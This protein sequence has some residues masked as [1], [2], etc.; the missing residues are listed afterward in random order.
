MQLERGVLRS[1]N[2]LNGVCAEC[3]SADC[4]E[5]ACKVRECG[6]IAGVSCGECP[7]KHYCSAEGACIDA[8]GD[9][10]C[11]AVDGV[12]CGECGEREPCMM[13]TGMCVPACVDRECGQDRGVS[14]G[15]CEDDEWCTADF[16]CQPACPGYECGT[17]H[18]VSCGECSSTDFCEEHE[19]YQACVD[20]ACGNDHGFDCGQCETGFLCELGQCVTGTCIASQAFCIDDDAYTCSDDATARML[21]DECTADEFCNEATGTCAQDLCTADEPYCAG[22]R[23]TTCTEDGGGGEAGGTDCAMLSASC[24]VL[25]CGTLRTDSI[26]PSPY[27]DLTDSEPQFGNIYLVN[28]TVTLTRIEADVFATTFDSY[29]ISTISVH[30]ADTLGGPYTSIYSSSQ[31]PVPTEDELN[32]VLT[33]GKYYAIIV[34]ADNPLMGGVRANRGQAPASPIATSFG[35][36]VSGHYAD[37]EDG[38]APIQPTAG[39]IYHQELSTLE[40]AQ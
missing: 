11:G 6:T 1:Q 19:C 24:H 18:G 35:T 2:C 9:R 25:G 36:V 3:E 30:R 40:L 33:A 14:C 10:T 26:R 28:K 37:I 31:S 8:C 27:A 16:Q 15:E 12:S 4:A 38:P 13:A 29:V 22:S 5:D 21:V 20:F 34:R 7:A 32:I 39:Y 23:L 17:N